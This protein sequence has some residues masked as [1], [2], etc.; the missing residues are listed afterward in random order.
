MYIKNASELV[1]NGEKRAERAARRLALEAVEAALIA[2]EPE[3][4]VASKVRVSGDQLVVGGERFDLSKFKRIL[5]IG[6][7]KA[8]GAMARA[9][10]PLL[11]DRITAGVVNVPDSQADG[12]DAPVRIRLH[13]ATHPLPSRSGVEGVEEMLE[14]VNEPKKDDLVI[15][16]ISGGGSSLLP[17]PREGISLGDKIEVTRRL[18][19]AGATIQELNVV[20][21]HLSGLK[22]GWLAERLSPSV[23]LS[24]V[25]SDVVGNRLDSIASGP[26]YPDS[27]TFSD[28]VEVLKKYR[29]LEDVPGRGSD[30][31]HERRCGEAPGD[32]KARLKVLQEGPQRHHRQ[33]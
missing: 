29:L 5:V 16:L 6:G 21:K 23:V 2:V 3:R 12:A 30:P 27:S 7:G 20:R 18:L 25:I 24:L 33:Q 11:R 17:M 26:L 32:P 10:E 28:A 22:G 1:E 19:L 13:R 4:L 14:L 31:A 9:I 15:C 8:S